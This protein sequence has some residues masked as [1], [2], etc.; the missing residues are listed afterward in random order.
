MEVVAS[1]KKLVFAPYRPEEV[2]KVIPHARVFLHGGAQC[3][4][5]NHGVEEAMVLRNMGLQNIPPP[6]NTYY[7]WPGRR[8]TPMAH[9][10]ETAAFLNSYRRALC[11][12]GPGT[13]KT[14][15][16]LWAADFLMREGIIKRVL[17]VAPLST[18]Q[19][20]WAKELK[21]HLPFRSYQILTGNRERKERLFSTPAHYYIIN[22]DGFTAFQWAL[23][24]VDLVIYDEATA[25]KTPSAQRFRI[26]QKWMTEN[27]PWLWMLTG[28]PISQSPVDAWTL[29]KLVQS[30][31]VPRSFTAFRDVVM[32]KISMYKWVPRPD[33]LETC[34]KVLQ[35]SIRFSLDECIELPTT[36][37]V[38]RETELT[39]PQ[40]RAYKQMENTAVAVF[41]KGHVVA[42]NAA[43]TLGKLLQIACGVV[44][45]NNGGEIGIDASLRYDALLELLDEIGVQQ[46]AGSSE[47][48]IIFVPLRGV[49]DWLTK[50]LAGAGYAVATVHGDVTPKARTDIFRAFQSDEAPNVLVAHPRVAAHGLD[51]TRSKHVIWF[52]P[53]FSLEQYEQ[54]NARISRLTT[55]GK[56]T[57]F[58]LFATPL[59]KELYRRLQ[60]KK[61][62]LA[63]FLELVR[64]VNK[65]DL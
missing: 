5:V 20:V 59:E 40:Q 13:G 52:A 15:S 24:G 27:N 49:Q 65:D 43:V 35:P 7:D 33:A 32:N 37:Y 34:K 36:N 12:N 51:L 38:S 58:H 64:G 39:P 50:S 8:I 11:L 17:V 2:T 31:A 57:I 23:T 42:A 14:L 29:A 44:Y 9:Q 48:A 45:D 55:R 26:F 10:K 16:A 28:T 25:L 3:V 21:Q 60:H 62:V 46:G 1:H 41:S 4:A 47:K 30:T 18:L 54:A 53:I 19:S 63:D 22:H 61:Q 6:I 56:T